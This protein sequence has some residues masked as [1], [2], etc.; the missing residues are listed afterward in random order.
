MEAG[1]ADVA[2]GAA[3]DR[4]RALGVSGHDVVRTARHR[5]DSWVRR[6]QLTVGMD[7]CSAVRL[8]LLT[9]AAR[10]RRGAQRLRATVSQGFTRPRKAEMLVPL[11]TGRR[12]LVLIRR[13][14]PNPL[15][16]D[17]KSSSC[18]TCRYLTAR[19]GPR[20]HTHA[21]CPSGSVRLMLLGP[22]WRGCVGVQASGSSCSI[23]ASARP[24]ETRASCSMANPGTRH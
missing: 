3:I 8:S 6:A 12:A 15:T 2:L 21:A 19:A 10:G 23:S 20:P 4:V 16:T 18:E 11:P 13:L 22:I 5:G 24:S 1:A 14:G 9:S 7:T 17:G